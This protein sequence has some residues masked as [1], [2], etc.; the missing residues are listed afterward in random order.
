LVSYHK[1]PVVT[2][3]KTWTLIFTAVK[4]PDLPL[5]MIQLSWPISS[6]SDPVL[7]AGD[8]QILR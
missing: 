4:T 8:T 3:Q 2:N 6:I 1:L 5:D 7:S